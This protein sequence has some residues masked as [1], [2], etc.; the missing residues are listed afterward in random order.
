MP[1]RVDNASRM[2]NEKMQI[3]VVKNRLERWKATGVVALSDC[4]LKV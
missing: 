1:R 4:S 2:V 3:P